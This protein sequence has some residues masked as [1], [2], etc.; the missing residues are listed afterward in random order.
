MKQKKALISQVGVIFSYNFRAVQ[1]IQED[2]V[3]PGQDIE[4]HVV[5][6]H[7]DVLLPLLPAEAR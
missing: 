2:N 4:V 5:G 3:H 1:D 6:E 7:C